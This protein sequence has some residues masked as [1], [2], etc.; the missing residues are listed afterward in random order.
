M[1][2][3]VAKIIVTIG[4]DTYQLE[5]AVG[6]S[7]KEINRKTTYDMWAKRKADLLQAI[8]A[9]KARKKAIED[10]WKKEAAEKKAELGIGIREALRKLEENDYMY[11]A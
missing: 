11:Q 4:G 9:K 8:R 3:E 6:K 5:Q 7:K 2:G 1:A 10:R